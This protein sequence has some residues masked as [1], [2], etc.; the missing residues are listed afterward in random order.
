[1]IQKTI[2]L[3]CRI[4]PARCFSCFLCLA[5][6]VAG[7]APQQ[8][9]LRQGWN[10]QEGIEVLL[11]LAAADFQGLADLKAEAEI[12]YQQAGRKDRGM[13]VILFKNP[14]LFK[15]EVRGPFYSHVFTALLQADSLTIVNREGAWRGSARG[16]LLWQLTYID[17]GRYDLRY[18][19]LGLVEPGRVDSSRALEYPRADRVIVPLRGSGFARRVWIDLYRGF[20][21]REEITFADGELLLSREL[22]DYQEVG[23]IYLPRRVEIHQGEVDLILDYRKY[24]ADRGIPDEH[25]TQDIPLER[26]Q[27]VD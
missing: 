19:L 9:L 21:T 11:G 16:S 14:D 15:M 7:C 2:D 22:K 26:L 4:T 23:G 10:H 8:P 13:A 5:L 25:F 18:G 20:I 6:L 24:F 17:F 3:F 27:R 12:T 1:V